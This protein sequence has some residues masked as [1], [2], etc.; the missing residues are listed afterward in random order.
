MSHFLP[1]KKIE[2]L[3]VPFYAF[4]VFVFFFIGEN[5]TNYF[6]YNEQNYTNITNV[7]QAII[8]IIGATFCFL[9][10]FFYTY[11]NFFA[12]SFPSCITIKNGGKLTGIYKYVRHP[13][14]YIFF[15]ITFGTS[16]CLRNTILFILAGMNHTCLYFYYMIEESQIKKINPYYGE[17]LKITNRFLPNFLKLKFNK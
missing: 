4:E 3:T 15:L 5:L 12:K 13:S 7:L 14:F 10:F 16:F 11:V 17:Y 6:F 9:S 2:F 1:N 8:F